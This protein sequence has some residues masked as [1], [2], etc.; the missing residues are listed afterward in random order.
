MLLLTEILQVYVSLNLRLIDG[1]YFKKLK[2][3]TITNEIIFL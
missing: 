2:F 1:V 3:K